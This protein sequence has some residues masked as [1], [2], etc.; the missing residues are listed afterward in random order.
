MFGFSKSKCQSAEDDVKSSKLKKKWFF[1]LNKGLQRTRNR[2]TDALS[3]LILGKKTIDVDLLDKL[4][5]ILLTADVGMKASQS[6]LKKLSHQVARK[7]LSD[8]TALMS[9]LRTELL[10]ILEPCQYPL[11]INQSP[12]VILI[13]GVNGV[14]KTTTV[15][16]L[17]H[18]YQ[19]Q[20]KR[21]MLAAGDTFRAAAIEQLQT[22][23]ERN[24]VPVIAQQPG[25]DSASV[26]YDA[27]KAAMARNYDILIVDTAGRLHTKSYLM[28]ELKKIKHVMKKV[29]PEAPHETLLIIDAGTGQ[30]AINQVEQFN[31]YI[32]LNGISLTK[33]D[34]TAK[35][36][37]IFGIAKKIQ[38]PI[39][40]VCVGE[41]I[42]D[43]ITFDAEEFITVL[44]EI[45]T[46]DLF[47]R[48]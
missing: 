33:L 22:W 34:G 41:Q 43:L 1:R 15:A 46:R 18:F 12:F 47:Y 7:S 4:E 28:E 44:L 10:A 39:R 27:M 30:N 29:N 32:G 19:L 2:L 24:Q 38:L 8:P 42:D 20:N 25:A 40:F 35:G 37:V 6:I 17:A 48:F 36:G 31:E 23:G 5:M 45:K 9:A 13:V 3:H 14:G 21:V 16:K 11:N 26:I